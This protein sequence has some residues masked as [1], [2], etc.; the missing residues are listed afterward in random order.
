MTKAIHLCGQFKRQYKTLHL[1]QVGDRETKRNRL[2]LLV[3]IRTSWRLGVVLY[4]K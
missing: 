3:K 1:S 4:R 2:Q